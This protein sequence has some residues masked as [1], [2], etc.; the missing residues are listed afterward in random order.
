MKELPGFTSCNEQKLSFNCSLQN[1]T[2]IHP[3]EGLIE[4]GPYSKDLIISQTKAI[5]I[6]V[7]YPTNGFR[8]IERI[9]S[10]LKNNHIPL[11]RK[12]Y[13]KNYIGFKNIFGIDIELLD[14]NKCIEIPEN[15]IENNKINKPHISLGNEIGNAIRSISNSRQ[16]F[17]VLF[18]LLPEKWIAGFENLE[19]DFNLHDLIKS[20]A[21]SYNIATQIIREDSTLSYKCRCSVM[22]RIS[23]ALYVK[24]GG[25]PWKLSGFDDETA[26]IG[27]S[28]STK[29][30]QYNNN[31]DFIT[32]CSQVFDSDG[33]GLEFIAYETDEISHRI[34]KNPF[35]SR[36]EMRKVM[37]RSLALYQKRHFGK[38]PKKIVVHKTTH[39]TNDE[40]NGCFDAFP[41]NTKIELL[42]IVQNVNWKG[43]NVASSTSVDAYPVNRNSFLQINKNEILLWTQGNVLINGNPFYK[44]GKGIPSPL[45]IVRFAGEGGWFEN[46]KII[47]GLTKMNWNHDGLYDRLPVTLGYASILATTIKRIGDLYNRPYEFRFFM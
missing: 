27:L 32:C 10:E 41:Q 44:E 46:S 42:Q 9:I 40:I 14:S 5:R 36:S 47:L 6:A 1:A 3:L 31:Y 12:K 20:T 19:D 2:S 34:G 33:T 18:I 16:E 43:I 22:W 23:I 45:K 13:L 29:Y 35:L 15:L 4:F 24:A 17:D 8:K 28:Y 25:I 11:E 38:T 21:A 39:F 7:I 30:N 37:S 26:L